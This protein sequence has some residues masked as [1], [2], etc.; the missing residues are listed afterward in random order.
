MFNKIANYFLLFVMT[1]VGVA[2]GAFFY[3]I[4]FPFLVVRDL[5]GEEKF[6]YSYLDNLP[7]DSEMKKTLKEQSVLFGNRVY[8]MG[9]LVSLFALGMIAYSTRYFVGYNT[10]QL[11]LYNLTNYFALW[12]AGIVWNLVRVDVSKLK[13]EKITYGMSLGDGPVRHSTH[14]KFTEN[15]KEESKNDNA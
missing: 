2:A 10:L 6:D 7:F 11:V 13:L 15:Q 5:R 8:A 14:Y 9:Y 12:A 3:G 4:S 1:V